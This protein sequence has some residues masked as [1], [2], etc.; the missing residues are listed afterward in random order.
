MA[1]GATLNLQSYD[2]T[3]AIALLNGTVNGVG[4]VAG[5]LLFTDSKGG[6]GRTSL[7]AATPAGTGTLTAAQYQLNGA[8]INANLGTG[9]LF[10][11]GGVS[12]LNGTAAAELVSVQAGTL[13][14]GADDR[15][16][17]TATLF[18][19]SAGTGTLTAAEYQL[20]GATINANLGAGTLF[21]LGGVSTL[22]GTAAAGLVSVQAGTLRLGA[23][24]RLADTATA[25]VSIGAT[26]D[27]QGFD[28][29]VALTALGGTLNGTG[30][31]TAAEYQLNGATIN[32]NLGAGSLFN[33]GGVSTLSGTAA[34]GLVSVQAGTLRL[35]ADERLA[36][37]ATVSVSSGATFDLDGHDETVGALSGMGTVAIG[38]G[39]LTF[40]GTDTGFGG[41]LTG[42]GSLVHTG[43]LFALSGNH[44]LASL[45]STG[46]ELRFL[47]T[48]TTGGVSVTGG[49]LTGSGTIGGA[50][51]M[52]T[53]ATLSPGMAGQ[54]GSIGS[55]SAGSLSLNGA[56]LSLGVLGTAGGNLSDTLVISGTADLTGGLIAPSFLAPAGGYDFVTRYTFLT[57]GNLVGTFTNGDAF[58]AASG[59]T[60]MYWRVVYDLTPNAAVLE[61][62][63]LIDFS[64]GV[65]GSANQNA[66]GQALS[67]GQLDAGADWAGVLDLLSGLN[68]PQQQA[69]FDSMGGEALADMSS[70]LLA[71]NDAFNGA[72]RQAGA[73]RTPGATPLNFASAFSFVGGRD[74]ASAMVTG[75]LDAFDPSAG[76]G[77][78]DGGW[79]S[80]H[81]SDV[82]LDGKAGQADLQ[83]RLNAFVGGY[84][85]GAG[86]YVLGAA[87]GA[88]RV[89]G[90]V[91]QRRSSFESDL[92]HAAVYARFDDGRWAADL[93]ASAYGGELDSRRTI[94]VGAFTG[95][96]NGKT[97]G[98]GQSL[99]ASVARRYVYED[100]SAISVGLM[101][102]L[103]RSTVDAFTETGAGGL[104]LQFED[105]ERNWQ[106][107]QVNLRG[108]Q[109]YQLSGQPLRLY[110]GLGVLVTTGDREAG[111]DLRFSGAA[112]GFGGYAIEGAQAAPL[113][114]TTEFGFEYQPREGLT[115]STGYR[116]VFSERLHDNQ[117]GARMSVSW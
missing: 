24:E 49:S 66:V 16:A 109:D 61:L 8:T 114:A 47:G 50:L 107:T 54:A 104:S 53:G 80:V 32:A 36:D 29:T 51:T 46:G 112:T 6:D 58:A 108:T 95:Q 34:A 63:K 115:L 28:E 79:I 84:A 43:G 26:L 27:L 71:A 72:V 65:G 11:T 92:L 75:V 48:T 52:A 91:G 106:T 94:T 7:P 39:Q 117:I 87:A 13:R 5:P 22:S 1:S 41:T 98:E 78:A 57:A 73:S 88:T 116:G 14:L 89:E 3:V 100:G 33:L 67:G 56:T 105:Q 60:G 9:D 2:E 38:A 93:T 20:N 70:S 59:Q 44:T 62:R 68:G 85:V 110:G 55:L 102:T 4:T 77:S 86:D 113:A 17:D 101:Q 23:D 19:A 64:Q 97:H 76:T 10:N 12:T 35:G 69:A 21:N 103:S 18:V 82:D 45:N 25:S 99:S 83:T 81:A 111:A 96:A 15:L 37:T 90:E 42:S 40:G 74:G 30:T 31:L